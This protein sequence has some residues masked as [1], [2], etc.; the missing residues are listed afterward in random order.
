MAPDESNDGDTV[1]DPT[2]DSRRD[3][4]HRGKR[5]KLAWKSAPMHALVDLEDKEAVWCVLDG[6]EPQR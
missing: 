4:A 5:A 2:R 6:D 3:E 1:S